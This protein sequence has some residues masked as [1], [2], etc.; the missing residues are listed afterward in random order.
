MLD[1]EKRVKLLKDCFNSYLFAEM[2]NYEVNDKDI[3]E[4][5]YDAKYGVYILFSGVIEKAFQ[6]SIK[7]SCDESEG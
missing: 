3:K 1:I 2:K 4:T 7:Q 5:E 6:S